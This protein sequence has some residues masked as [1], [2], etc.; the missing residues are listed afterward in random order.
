[1]TARRLFVAAWLPDAARREAEDVAARLG[2]S[3]ADVRWVPTEDL[4]VTLCFL[5][6]VDAAR[7]ESLVACLSEVF[8]GSTAFGLRLAGLGRFPVRGMPRVVW[9]GLDAGAG[10]L[11]ALASL[12]ERAL[13]AERF[14]GR[15]DERPFRAHVTLGRPKSSRGVGRLLDLLG[16]V[17]L[18][19]GTHPLEEVVLAESRLSPRGALYTAVARFPLLD[20]RTVA[21][22]SN[23]QGESP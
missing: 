17:H 14:L 10:E 21:K 5:G 13:L 23:H 15:I 20:G 16:E 11:A 4:H 1:V 22:V 8:S 6:G 12:A 7:V 18:L 19:G 3:G 2:E 9:A